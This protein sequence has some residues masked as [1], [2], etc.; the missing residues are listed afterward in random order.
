M[1]R[2]IIRAFAVAAQLLLTAGLVQAA[3]MVASGT[4][5]KSVFAGGGT[6]E[7]NDA[8]VMTHPV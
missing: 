2:G 7:R 3:T 5:P 8:K 6:V 4:L 1:T